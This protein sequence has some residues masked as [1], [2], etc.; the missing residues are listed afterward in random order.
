ML[1][2]LF[3][4][5]SAAT[6][7]FQLA[8]SLRRDCL[9]LRQ[10]RDSL[11]LMRNE[12]SACGTMLPQVFALMAVGVNGDLED[13]FSKVAKNMEQNPWVTPAEAL[14]CAIGDEQLPAIKEILLPLGKKL[15]KYDADVQLRGIDSA[16]Q[17]TENIIFNCE[18]EKKMKSGTYRTLGICTGLAVAIL[19]V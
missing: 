5:C 13:I 9:V 14:A 11:Q 17:Q 19:L 3:V 1:G 16:L 15:G 2:I 8:A 18:Q 7:G 10:L 6:T 12:I 4:V